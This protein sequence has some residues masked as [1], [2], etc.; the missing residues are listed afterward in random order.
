MH[1]DKPL[2]TIENEGS[3]DLIVFKNKR[4]G[5]VANPLT[6]KIFDCYLLLKRIASFS[7]MY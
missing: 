2:F 4:I 5:K 7:S 3:S 1:M 6:E